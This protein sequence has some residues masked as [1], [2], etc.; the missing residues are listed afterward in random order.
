MFPI[1]YAQ[2]PPTVVDHW[3]LPVQH[4]GLDDSF[5]PQYCATC[6]ADKYQEWQGSQHSKAFSPGLVGQIMD[7]KD[8][9]ARN[10]LTCHAPL[11][12][13]QD[14]AMHQGNLFK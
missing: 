6:H 9:D 12:E 11:A 3:Q 4:Q 10:C 2:K 1:L 5:A 13:Q 14:E 8:S 7:Y